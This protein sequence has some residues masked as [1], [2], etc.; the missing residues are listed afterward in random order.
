MASQ[1]TTD[2]LT[3]WS[4][5]PEDVAGEIFKHTA[6]HEGTLLSLVLVSKSIRSLTIPHLFSELEFG[7]VG[8]F[9]E[10]REMVAREP[11]MAT[12][13]K[14]VEVALSEHEITSVADVGP[15]APLL[16]VDLVIWRGNLRIFTGFIPLF[17]NATRFGIKKTSNYTFQ[18]LCNFLG[19]CGRMRAL[20][21]SETD[22]KDRGMGHGQIPFAP[23][24]LSALEDLS[25]IRVGDRKKN[26]FIRLLNASQPHNLKSLSFGDMFRDEPCSLQSAERLLQFAA[27]TVCELLL[28]PLFPDSDPAQERI[29]QMFEQL[30]SFTALESLTIWLGVEDRYALDVVNA[31]QGAPNLTSLTFRISFDQ[32]DNNIYTTEFLPLLDN[33]LQWGA[34]ESM[35]TILN[36]KYPLCPRVVFQFCA[37]RYLVFHHQPNL[38]RKMERK[39]KRKL[40]QIGLDIEEYLVVEW[41]DDQ[42]VR[43]GYRFQDGKPLW[44]PANTGVVDVSSEDSDEE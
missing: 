14:R 35:K 42:Y 9:Q 20:T 36:C 37:P 26:Y 33:S 31:L 34:A 32:A 44:A 12:C 7:G 13:P 24:D 4:T 40:G 25:V 17:P 3:L 28:D 22:Y 19:A 41:V 16:N 15:I 27:P 23:L 30:P 38:R 43:L 8:R 10:W 5:I 2:S 6:D 21:F 18:Q 29:M 11:R 1:S 39:L